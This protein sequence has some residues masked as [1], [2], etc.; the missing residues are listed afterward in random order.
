MKII[1]DLNRCLAYAQC[2]F[3]APS[4]FKLVA[5]EILAYDPAPPAEVRDDILRAIH[6]CPV[7]AISI[8]IED[9]EDL[10]R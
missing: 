7:Q 4:S 2:C 3:A 8:D 9:A 1:V 10:E 6:A 5:D